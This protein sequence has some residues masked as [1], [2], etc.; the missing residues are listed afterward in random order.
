[1]FCSQSNYSK[2]NKY[3]ILNVLIAIK[4]TVDTTDL[5]FLVFGLQSSYRR[6]NQYDT[7]YFLF[8]GKLW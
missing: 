1:M 3:D 5:T 4:L 2:H 7:L 6:H 8:T